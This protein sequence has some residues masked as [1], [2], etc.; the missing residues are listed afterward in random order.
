MDELESRFGYK[1]K[2][3]IVP[4]WRLVKLIGIGNFGEVWEGVGPGRVQGAVKIV[5][6]TALPGKVERKALERIRDLK[7]PH[8]VAIFGIYS[9]NRAGGVIDDVTTSSAEIPSADTGTLVFDYS[10]AESAV[11][12]VITMQ[13]GEMSLFDRLKQCKSE[14]KKGI[15]SQELLRYM[16]HAAEAIDYLNEPIH[17]LGEGPV[18]IVHCDIKPQ[19]L[20]LVGGGAQICD[21]SLVRP[22]QDVQKTAMGGSCT[23]AYAAPEL[24]VGKPCVTSDQYCLALSYVELRTGELPYPPDT[25]VTE[26][27]YVKYERRLDLSA[28]APPVQEVVRKATDPDETARFASCCEMVEALRQAEALRESTRP[29]WFPPRI[30]LS[31]TARKKV[32]TGFAALTLAAAALLAWWFWPSKVEELVKHR[33]FD[34]AFKYTIAVEDRKKFDWVLDEWKKCVKSELSDK[35][36][37]KRDFQK[38]LDYLARRRAASMTPPRRNGCE[39]P[40]SSFAR[41]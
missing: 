6:L 16:Q 10:K 12:L 41:P 5:D 23:P 2:H 15:P 22:V 4:G 39:R 3:P 20:L 11:R 36:V 14:G 37:Y 28:L 38:A 18:S 21:Y 8:L 9:L 34:K 24:H 40:A 25:K 26:L 19:N 32:L 17:D 1:P 30:K 33:E 7:N 35:D 13:L 27:F 29:R 31:K